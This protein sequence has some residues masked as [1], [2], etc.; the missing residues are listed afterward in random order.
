MEL[1]KMLESIN[2]K[3]QKTAD[4]KFVFGEMIET[5]EKSIIPVSAIRYSIGGGSGH[6]PDLSKI[7][8][9]AKE[10]SEEEVS[11]N[12]PGGEGI[13]GKFSNQPLGV[14][15]ITGENTRFVPVIPVKAI[16][17]AI[18]IWLVTRIFK[19]RRK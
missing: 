8:G 5:K 7:K 1:K 16:M 18:S 19:K 2:E 11:E 6:G 3:L 15:E 14:F 17:V 10:T 12:R 9:I 4:V 13:G